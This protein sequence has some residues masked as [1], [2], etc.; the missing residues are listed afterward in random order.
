MKVM[1]TFFILTLVQPAMA[2]LP[3][4]LAPV[5]LARA[6]VSEGYNLPKLSFLGSASPVINNRGDVSFKLMGFDGNA[7]QGL[8]VKRGSE[9]NGRIVYTA[10][11]MRFVTD[12][13]LNNQGQIAFNLFDEGFTDGIFTLDVETGK[14]QQAVEADENIA[15]YNYTQVLSDGKIYFRGTN[16]ENSRTFYQYDDS[17]KTSITEGSTAFGQK[18][19]YLFKPYMNDSGALTFKRRLGEEGQWDEGNGDEI[20]LLKPAGSSYEA[21]VIAKDKDSDSD[22]QFRG[23]L[24]SSSLSNNGMVTF[25]GVLEDNTKVIM[26]YKDGV[27]KNLAA[28]KSDDIL[29]IE[30]FS[31]KVNDL[32]QVVFRAKNGEGKRGVYLADVDGVK[33]IIG[34]GDTVITDLG[35]GKILSNPNYPGLGGDVDMNDHGDIVFQCLEEQKTITSGALQFI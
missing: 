23:F 11:D 10:P 27:L 32:G 4:Y 24:N 35:L 8:W 5:L 6:N 16:H 7:D 30:Y 14:V 20:I 17:L 31:P 15:Y 18:S 3:E 19:S 21:V 9:E 29:E 25:I 34:E 28:E 12:P 2:A 1:L 26:L 33:R 13:T 22:S